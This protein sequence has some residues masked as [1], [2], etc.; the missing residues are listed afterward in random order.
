MN[1]CDSRSGQQGCYSF[2]ITNQSWLGGS[3]TFIQPPQLLDSI[4][5]QILTTN[6]PKFFQCKFDGL[7]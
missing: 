1:S 3:V 5:V 2:L 7:S 4:M 6:F